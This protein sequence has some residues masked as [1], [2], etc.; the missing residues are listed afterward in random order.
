MNS[1]FEI[2]AFL[3]IGSLTLGAAVAAVGLRDT[4]HCGLSLAVV[5][6]GVAGL[7]L[8]LDAEFIGFIQLLVYVG[9][10]AVLV[11]FVILI[12][13]P[14]DGVIQQPDRRRQKLPG[15]LIAAGIF[16]VTYGAIM[17][18]PSLRRDVPE[19]AAL[20]IRAVGEALVSGHLLPLMAIGV[21]LTTALIGAAL[22]AMEGEDGK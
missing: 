11:M 20:S 10:V 9:A 7:Y 22:F 13:R 12:T 19:P 17:Q 4:V 6:V 2:I 3:L 1:L 18:S 16:L 15:A 21:L 14:E 5:F 8:L